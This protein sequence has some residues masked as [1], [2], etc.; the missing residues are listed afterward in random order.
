MEGFALNLGDG[1]VGTSPPT[2]DTLP[3]VLGC[4]D[5]ISLDWRLKRC[6]F[7]KF[8]RPGSPRSDRQHGQVVGEGSLPGLPAAAFSLC[9]PIMVRGMEGERAELS[10]ACLF[11][12]GLQYYRGA[13][14]LMTRPPPSSNPM[15]LGLRVSTD[16]FGGGLQ[17][18]ICSALLCDLGVS[19]HGVWMGI[20]VQRKWRFTKMPGQQSSEQVSPAS[21]D[22]AKDVTYRTRRRTWQGSGAGVILGTWEVVGTRDRSLLA[23]SAQSW[24]DIRNLCLH[25][26]W[27]LAA[28]S[29]LVP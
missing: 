21:F 11:S 15:T 24:A 6:F 2:I 27:C 23:Q 16:E 20:R 1:R 22:E 4:Y 14:T 7:L 18:S 28:A 19:K 8:W 3:F 9:S 5:N 25:C 29:W 12:Q 13:S 10:H 17:Y 26:A